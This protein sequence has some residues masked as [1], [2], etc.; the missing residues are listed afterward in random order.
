MTG[1]QTC[2]LPISYGSS[3]AYD[4]ANILNQMQGGSSKKSGNA[5]G[6]SKSPAAASLS[7]KNKSSAGKPIAEEEGWDILDEILAEGLELYGEEGLEEILT[8]FAVSG[9]ISQELAEL[10]SDK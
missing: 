10:L 8:S 2:A 1:V 5:V 7:P 4:L 9:E 3:D 6:V